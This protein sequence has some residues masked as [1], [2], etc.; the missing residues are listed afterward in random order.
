M[1]MGVGDNSYFVYAVRYIVNSI[2][3]L[4]RESS[5]INIYH[6]NHFV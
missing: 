1:W 3:E 6:G 5:E 4:R 2:S